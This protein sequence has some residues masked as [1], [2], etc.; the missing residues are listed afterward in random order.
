MSE[1][2]IVQDDPAEIIIQQDAP[3]EVTIASIGVQGPTGAAG[4]PGAT[5]PQGPPGN[6]APSDH[7]LLSNIGVNTHATIDL[8]ISSTANPHN[9]T[10]TQVGLSD[11]DNTSD[12]AK[13]VS[14]AQQTA[15]N[16]K[17]NIASPTFTGTVSGITKAMVGLGNVDNTSDLLKPISND[18]QAALDLKQDASSAVTLTGV[19]TLTNKTL[20]SPVINSPTGIVKADVGL[21][22]VDNTSD[23]NKP[24]STATQT[25]LNLKEDSA[26]KAQ[27]NGYASLNGAGQVPTAQIPTTLFNYLGAWNALTNT[28]TLIDGTGT[29][30]DQY[31]VNVAGTQDLGSGPQSF[32]LGDYVIYNG[33][34]WERIPNTDAVSSVAGKLGVVV[35]D[36]SDVGLSN[37]DN[38][39]DANKPIS[40]ATQT[41]LNTK[42]DENAAIVGATKT[43]ITYDSKGLVT[44]GVDATT[45]DIADSTDKR[46][47][48]DANLL[49]IGNTSGVNTGDQN[50]ETAEVDF[51][52]V[53]D[54]AITTVPALWI[55]PTSTLSLA[56]T[57]NLIDHDIEDALLERIVCTYG[58]IVDGVSFDVHC[59][60]PNETHGRYNIKIMGV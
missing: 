44:A 17:A 22:N 33:A 32:S 6:D 42:V 36:K 56:I 47:V 8:H 20:T 38:T 37:V 40:T 10:K 7:T 14:T 15:L 60:A 30:K 25:A 11:V 13:P 52:A 16:L 31:I 45:A 57:P 53:S 46:Y 35:L 39:S 2:I 34:E 3:N 51:G 26:N 41:A 27:P 55:T 28:P 43:K 23:V 48:T 21:S 9:V 58:N 54:Y 1:V 18:T 50:F 49:V 19:Q 5:G 59:H 12:A 24:I 4:T 29:I